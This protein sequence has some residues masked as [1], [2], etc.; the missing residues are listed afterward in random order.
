MRIAFSIAALMI[1]SL[2]V[3]LVV[4][5]GDLSPAT[6]VR[7][8]LTNVMQTSQARYDAQSTF[9][10]LS[11]RT[12]KFCYLI[13]EPVEA[14]I[15]IA[16]LSQHPVTIWKSLRF[17][18]MDELQRITLYVDGRSNLSTL[19]VTVLHEEQTPEE[20][21]STLFPYEAS[22]A[23]FPSLLSF[24]AGYEGVSEIVEGE[25]ELV[26]EYRNDIPGRLRDI[27]SQTDLQ[28]VDFEYE[29]TDVWTG[30][31][32]SYPIIIRIVSDLT[33][34]PDALDYP[35]FTPLPLALTPQ[36]EPDWWR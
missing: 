11:L 26:I 36:R 18:T 13:G 7:V 23:L 29:P 17:F 20:E 21:Y 5:A 25:Y 34:C 10:N 35:T 12:N 33:Q 22:V 31:L 14:R 3:L 24:M 4:V 6:T 16:N 15:E 8:S 32:R 30:T 1:V 2:L 9:L 27:I 19:H 28:S